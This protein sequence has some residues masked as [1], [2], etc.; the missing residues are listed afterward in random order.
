MKAPKNGRKPAA[1]TEVQCRD[2]GEKWMKLTQTLKVW[3]GHCLACSYKHRVLTARFYE[4]RRAVGESMRSSD[5]I[6]K[7][8]G[9]LT[10]EADLGMRPGKRHFWLC[11]CDCGSRA[12]VRQ[13]NLG[14]YTNSCGCLNRTRPRARHGHS[15]DDRRSLTYMSWSSMKQRC[16]NPASDSFASY[17]GRG[18]TV[19]ERWLTFEHFLADMGE[20]PPGTSLDRIDNASGYSPDNCRWASATEQLR[21]TTRNVMVE[22]RGELLTVSAWAEK[23]GLHPRTLAARLSRGWSTERALTTPTNH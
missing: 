15:G 9:L 1:R 12:E 7:R 18:I 2:C 13:S 20:R 17:G 23:L 22:F 21:N 4:A 5:M 16:S 10:V 14:R 8:F 11:L 3:H 19:C 6:G